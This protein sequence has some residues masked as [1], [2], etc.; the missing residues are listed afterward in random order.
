[1]IFRTYIYFACD[2]L[3]IA[4]EATDIIYE[5][6]SLYEACFDAKRWF[7]NRNEAIP[8]WFQTLLCI[9]VH[10]LKPVR[11]DDD[12]YLPPNSYQAFEWKHDWPGTFEDWVEI[13]TKDW[14]PI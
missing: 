4:E 3:P 10:V 9:K 2:R 5:A 12:G 6:E 13:E 1:M 14:K 8:D 11:P 7:E